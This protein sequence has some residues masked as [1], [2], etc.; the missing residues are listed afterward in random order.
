MDDSFYLFPR[1]P[2]KGNVTV[3]TPHLVA[4]ANFKDTDGAVRTALCLLVHEA[5]R[6]DGRRITL[7]LW[8]VSI[9]AVS[10]DL[11]ETSAALVGEFDKATAVVVGAGGDDFIVVFFDG[12]VRGER[13]S[14]KL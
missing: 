9:G 2:V 8:G 7:V 4:S 3:S 1:L 13:A 5:E 12:A 11:A 6:V 10:T 14:F